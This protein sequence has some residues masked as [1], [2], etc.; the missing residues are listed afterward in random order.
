M[1]H[2]Y[3]QDGHR[4]KRDS[5]SGTESWDW[6]HTRLLMVEISVVNLRQEYGPS[7]W[8]I[9]AGEGSEIPVL[10]QKWDWTAH[11]RISW[12]ILLE[13]GQRRLCPCKNR[14]TLLDDG[15]LDQ[16]LRGSLQISWT[17]RAVQVLQQPCLLKLWWRSLGLAFC[18]LRLSGQR[19]RRSISVGAGVGGTT[20][21]GLMG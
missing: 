9:C 18:N 20:A 12:T 10:Q 21:S 13:I 14:E 4:G 15:V 1:P 8:R 7:S 16:A 2:H 17:I 19:W 3:C 5:H 11:K 6:K